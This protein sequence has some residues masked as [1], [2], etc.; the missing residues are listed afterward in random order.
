MQSEGNGIIL[1]K[2][3]SKD[4][5]KSAL[6]IQVCTNMGQTKAFMGLCAPLV[7]HD[8]R[9]GHSLPDF[10][11]I[12][13]WWKDVELLCTTGVKNNIIYLLSVTCFKLI[14][15]FIINYHW[16]PVT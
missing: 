12:H 5:W 9:S 2:V 4:M 7:I 11:Y 14:V 3:L 10:D 1:Q 6:S 13:C 8:C 16:N 15:V